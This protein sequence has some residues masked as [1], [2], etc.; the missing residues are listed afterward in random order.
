MHTR[1]ADITSCIAYTTHAFLPQR[2]CLIISLLAYHS[3]A[4][5]QKI[6]KKK[7]T[8]DV[9]QKTQK[10]CGTFGSTE[11]FCMCWIHS[12]WA[13]V[14][15]EKKSQK[16]VLTL[17]TGKPNWCYLAN[18]TGPNNWFKYAALCTISCHII[19]MAPCSILLWDWDF[20][21]FSFLL[22]VLQ[23]HLANNCLMRKPDS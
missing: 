5:D 6:I 12:I 20:F 8:P 15:E 18:A 3:K 14:L 23:R 22:F 4:K 17:N 1:T 21:L 9:E 10:V 16:L 13:S 7:H 2:K 19:L 11:V